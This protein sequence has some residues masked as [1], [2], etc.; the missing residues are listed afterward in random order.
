MVGESWIVDI[1]LEGDLDGQS[2][3][4]D[5]GEV[6]KRLKRAI[7]S[8]VDHSLLVPGRSAALTIAREAGRTMLRFTSAHGDIEHHSPDAAVSVLDTDVVTADTLTAYLRPRLQAVLPAT[9]R[10]LGLSLRHEQIDGALYHYVHG[11]KKHDGLCQRI[12]HGHRSRIEVRI[13]GQRDATL[14]ADIAR[15]WRDIYLGTCEDIVSDDGERIHFAYTAAE[16]AYAL[17]LP[18]G[19][20]DL[21]E[22]DSTVEQIASKLLNKLMTSQK[23]GHSITVRAYEGVMKGALAAG[24]C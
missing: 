19:R 1:E 7:D 22:T 13:D 17:T 3:V 23:H 14:E 9:V 18:R 11:L 24:Q 2:M 16:G 21:L 4:L 5:F 6:K 20:V 15:Q 8:S 12:A 10:R